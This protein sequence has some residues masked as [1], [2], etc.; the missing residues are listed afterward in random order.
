VAIFYNDQSIV[1][2]LKRL[3]VLVKNITKCVFLRLKPQ[4]L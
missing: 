4:K 1:E 3:Q 2:K